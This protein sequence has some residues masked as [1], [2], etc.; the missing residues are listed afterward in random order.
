[1]DVILPT[2]APIGVRV[3]FWVAAV[4]LVISIAGF[5]RYAAAQHR[6]KVRN[7]F[8]PHL[9]IAVGTGLSCLAVM[10][11]AVHWASHVGGIWNWGV[12]AGLSGVALQ[13]FGALEMG[14]RRQPRSPE[15]FRDTK[16]ALQKNAERSS[17]TKM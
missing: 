1:M 10:L 5:A 8:R 11:L 13:L 17:T 14:S 9:S 4:G 2:D 7:Y 12:G 16:R 15:H 6:F 3:L